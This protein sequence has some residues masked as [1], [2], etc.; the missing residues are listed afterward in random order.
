MVEHWAPLPG[1]D[2]VGAC[3]VSAGH[4]LLALGQQAAEDDL[5]EHATTWRRGQIQHLITR[6]THG[7]YMI[8]G[9][10]QGL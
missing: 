3:G 10:V 8:W 5:Q 9:S 4:H 2:Q 7:N 6:D 1:V